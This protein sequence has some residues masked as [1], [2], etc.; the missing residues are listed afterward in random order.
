MKIESGK[1]V[2]ASSTTRRAGGAAPGFSPATDGPQ[3]VA[4]AAPTNAVPALD[5]LMALQGETDPLQRRAR[6]ARRG[7]AALDALENLMTGL[8]SGAAPEQAGDQLQR[9]RRDGESTGDAE[10]DLVL[11]EIDTRVEVELAKLEMAARSA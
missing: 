11:R 8:L 5:A 1:G 2:S 10:L 9:L 6:Q 3:R 7:R 4:Q